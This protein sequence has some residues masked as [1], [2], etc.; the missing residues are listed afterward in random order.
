MKRDLALVAATGAKTANENLSLSFSQKRFHTA[1][2]KLAASGVDINQ[3]Y[4]VIHPGV[5]ETKREYPRDLWIQ[6]AQLIRQH[7]K[8][9]ILLSGARNEKE[10]TDYI[11]VRAGEGSFSIAG[12]LDIE[13]FIALIARAPLLISVNT[14]A[15]HIAGIKN[16]RDRFICTHKSATPTMDDE[17]SGTAI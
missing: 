15:V 11:E 7:T 8:K 10:L 17:V 1:Q 12:L 4:I 9:Q 5:S 2:K 16:A 14:S 3:E 13:E 6:T